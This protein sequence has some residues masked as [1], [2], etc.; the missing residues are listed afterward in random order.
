MCNVIYIQLHLNQHNAI[1]EVYYKL[2]GSKRCNGS[3]KSNF[4]FAFFVISV[5]KIFLQN[6]PMKFLEINVV[7]DF[8]NRAG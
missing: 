4:F 8:V 3:K 1:Y 6:S 5:L 7:C 2:N